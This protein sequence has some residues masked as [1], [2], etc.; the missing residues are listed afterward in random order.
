VYSVALQSDGRI[1][2]GGNFIS[3]NSSSRGRVARI[4]SDGSI[5]TL[6]LATGAGANSPVWSAA[7]QGDGKILIGGEFTTYNGTNRGRIA[8]LNSN[9]SL[10]TT[11]L[12]TGAGANA[13][14]YSLALQS[15]GK[16]LIGGYF[17]TYNGTSRGYIARLNSDGSLDTSFLT[18]G[19]GASGTVWSIVQQSDGKIL[20]GGTFTAYNS[21]GRGCVARLNSD[22]SLDTSFLTAGAGANGTVFSVALQSDGRILVSGNF[23]TYNGVSRVHIARLWGD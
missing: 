9:G 1:I 14:V 20:I 11:F 5:D 4:N 22:G 16:V 13:G 17:T 19:A 15:D 18:T 23:T 12:N 2:I 21:A 7:I 3:Y 8:R 6:F 10:D